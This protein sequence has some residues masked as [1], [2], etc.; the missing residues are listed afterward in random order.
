MDFATG[1]KR[2]SWSAC[3]GALATVLTLVCSAYE[4]LPHVDP[5]P[6]INGTWVI[7]TRTVDTSYSAFRDLDLT[8]TVQL[9]QNGSNFTGSGEKTTENGHQV[10]GKAHTPITIMGTIE[11]N[12]IDASFTENGAERQSHGEFHWTLRKSSGTGTFMS[13]AA[14]SRGTSSLS[15]YTGGGR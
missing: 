11:G 4:I 9:I 2:F 10:V 3:A 13:T 14:N 12:S 8:Y 7:E 15:P 5:P 6:D 1:R